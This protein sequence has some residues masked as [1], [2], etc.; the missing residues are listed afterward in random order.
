MTDDAIVPQSFITNVHLPLWQQSEINRELPAMSSASS[1]H[2]PDLFDQ[3][4][5]V[6]LGA[7]VV[8]LSIA[9]AVSRRVLH[10]TTSTRYRVLFVWHAFD[11]LIHF[12]LEGSFLY[13][14]F[15][16][17]ILLADVPNADLGG[18]HPTPANFLG[19]SDRIY[20]AQAGG[21]NPFAQLWMVY[22]RA[23]KRWAGADLV[24]HP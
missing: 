5:L 19:H 24:C 2:P 3:T 17:Y 15:F 14:C 23:D 10:P 4:T 9:I 12:F 16:S 11:A 20:G 18:F 1:T 6:S 22:A 21:D 13:H 7:T 8:L